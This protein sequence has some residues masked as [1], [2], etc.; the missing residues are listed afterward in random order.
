[1][2]RRLSAAHELPEAVPEGENVLWQGSPGW[3]AMA[4]SLHIRVVAG[5]FGLLLVWFTI[6]R[7][8]RGHAL[9]PGLARFG[10]L[11]AVAIALFSFYAWLVARTTSY[12]FTNRRLVLQA[13]IALP[14][15]FN[16]PFGRITAASVRRRARGAGDIVL[17]LQ[18]GERL[19]FVALWPHARS[20]KAGVE[21]M[22]RALP[23]VERVSRIL[24]RLLAE[25]AELPPTH[26]TPSTTFAAP[27]TPGLPALSAVA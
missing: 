10:A 4:K 3:W 13:G 11:S 2:S 6:D 1:M 23:D 9:L 15:S 16:I 17:A 14:I 25:S 19:S 26:A 12:T 27:S 18:V 8:I 20:G 24:T 5:Y 21:P 7:L 22:L